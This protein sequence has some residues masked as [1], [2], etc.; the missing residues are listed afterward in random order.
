MSHHRNHFLQKLAQIEESAHYVLLE[1][2]GGLAEQHIR[3]IISLAKYL[4]TEIEMS[5][6]TRR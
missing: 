2:R 1:T 3:H 4:A 6:S 5:R